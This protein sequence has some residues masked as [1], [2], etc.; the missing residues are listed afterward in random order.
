MNACIH[1]NEYAH[2]PYRERETIREGGQRERGRE[3]DF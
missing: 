1:A 3:R 2:I